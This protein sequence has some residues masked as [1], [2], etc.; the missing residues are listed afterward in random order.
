V[1]EHYFSFG[2]KWRD[3]S[4]FGGVGLLLLVFLFAL[5]P[6]KNGSNAL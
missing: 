1:D 6:R 3:V 4:F 2:A 5:G